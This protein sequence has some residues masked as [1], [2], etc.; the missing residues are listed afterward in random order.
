MKLK[1]VAA[2]ADGVAMFSATTQPLPLS[3]ACLQSLC[4]SLNAPIVHM[5]ELPSG[6]ARA[7]VVVYAEQYGDLG[8]AVAVRSLEGGQVVLMRAQEPLP[9]DADPAQALETVMS[10]AEGLGFVFDEDMLAGNATHETR[11]AALDHWLR[12]NGSDEIFETPDVTSPPAPAG[13]AISPDPERMPE[14]EDLLSAASDGGGEPVELELD[15]LSLSD[16]GP[17]DLETGSDELLLDEIAPLEIGDEGDLHDELEGD[18]A[19]DLQV[20]ASGDARPGPQGARAG[21]E[22]AT[23]EITEPVA[24]GEAPMSQGESAAAGQAFAASP[25]SKFRR[26]ADDAGDEGDEAGAGGSAL[27]RVKIVRMKKAKDG[28][29]PSRARILASY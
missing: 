1:N 17:D 21:A 29:A 13:A 24:L 7:A 15:D 27:G 10:Y 22:H 2:P 25:L 5:D 8:M 3:E 28:R 18:L 20:V 23:A 4:A 14:M 16:I 6:P 9:P 11:L 26:P 12:L 19:E